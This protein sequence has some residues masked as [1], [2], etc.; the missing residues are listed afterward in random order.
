VP[1]VESWLAVRHLGVVYT[2]L[3]ELGAAPK[4]P[5]TVLVTLSGEGYVTK[6]ITETLEPEP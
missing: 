6:S 1:F 5:L 3:K 4:T 2:T